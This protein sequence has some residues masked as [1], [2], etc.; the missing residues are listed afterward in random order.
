MSEYLAAVQQE[1]QTKNINLTVF[2][3]DFYPL[4]EMFKDS[5]WSGYFTSRGNSKRIIREYSTTATISNTL[6]A[7]DMFKL[8]NLTS[9]LSQLAEA[10]YNNSGLLGLM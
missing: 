6:Y 4:E 9:N 2:N 1:I 3:E 7:L 8:Q 10:S 5:F